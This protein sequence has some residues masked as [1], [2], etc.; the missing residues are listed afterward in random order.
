MTAPHPEDNILALRQH[1]AIQRSEI[2]AL[3]PEKA[4]ARILEHPQPAALVHSFPEEDW[5]VLIHEIGP[6]DAGPLIALAAHKQL[7]YLLDQE[8]WQRDRIDFD[9]ARRW[10]ARLIGAESSP[11][12]MVRWLAKEKTNL[13]ELFLNRSIEVQIREHDQEASIFGPDFFSYD[14]VFYIRIL[15]PEEDSGPPGPKKTETLSQ[16]LIKRLLDQLAEDDFVRFQGI[17]LEAAN[18]LPAEIEEEAYRLRTVRLAEKGFLPFEEA[19]GLYQPIS[20]RDFHQKGQRQ[21]TMMPAQPDLF[22]MVPMTVLS[23][24]NLFTGALQ[25]IDHPE[26]RQALQEE[27]AALCNRLIVADQQ[28]INRRE[29]LAAVVAKASGYLHM[30]LQKLL[31]GDA[32]STTGAQAAARALRGYHLEALFKLGYSDALALKRTAEEWV[33]RSWFAARGLSLTFWGET[34]LGVIGGLLIKRPLCFD[35]YQTGRMYR[36]FARRE[37]LVWSRHQLEQVKLWDHL[38]ERIDPALAAPSTYGFLSYK[39][40]LL[41]LWARH[42]LSLPEEV[43]HIPAAAFQPFFKKLFGDRATSGTTSKPQIDTALRTD[44]LTW[45]SRR[46]KQP[47]SELSAIGASLEALFVELE[48]SYGRVRVD[49][50]DPRF[51]NHFLLESPAP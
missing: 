36:E 27:F 51:I 35:N 47:A 33:H 22:P 10:L 38:L 46:S 48:E 6:D 9:A 15:A 37:D 5:H 4:L 29:A 50:I 28:K 26:Q 34:W 8:L 18:V 32:P 39:N 49:Q 11:A 1:L 41:T 14:N 21:Q 30:G 44:F 3:A 25:H 31:P 20:D 23:E 24:G 17:L 12:R 19:V 16:N 43:G 45:L 42:C 2:L 7:E 40:L 13:I